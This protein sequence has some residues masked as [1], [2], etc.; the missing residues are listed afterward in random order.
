MELR[1]RFVDGNVKNNKLNLLNKKRSLIPWGLRVPP[2]WKINFN[3]IVEFC[4]VPWRERP[5][6]AI[7]CLEWLGRLKC[8]ATVKLRLCRLSLSRLSVSPMYN[9]L[10]RVDQLFGM[11]FWLKRCLCFLSHLRLRKD[12]IANL[13]PV[14]WL[15]IFLVTKLLNE[16][17]RNWSF[18][19]NKIFAQFPI[20]WFL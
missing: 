5:Q 13:K 17:N 18:S 20:H 8:Q 11:Y 10:F 2:I 9:F 14:S 4:G 15:V 1:Y 12:A 7:C 6:T 16:S 19:S 3:F